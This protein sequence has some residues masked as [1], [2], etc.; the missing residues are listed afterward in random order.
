[1]STYLLIIKAKTSIAEG[2]ISFASPVNGSSISN[3]VQ[4][5]RGVATFKVEMVSLKKEYLD[6][7][8]KRVE[9]YTHCKYW[10]W[11]TFA[12]QSFPQRQIEDHKVWKS[13]VR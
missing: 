4:S 1:M 12:C 3:N 6:M 7:Y 2:R 8:A 13:L 5:E 9:L 10:I 11:Q